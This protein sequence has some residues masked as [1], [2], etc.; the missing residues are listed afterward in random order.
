MQRLS[1]Y[2][3]ST[4]KQVIDFFE[5]II[6]G[7]S[8]SSR[9][10]YQVVVNSL[11]DYISSRSAYNQPFNI[12]VIEDW[13]IWISQHNLANKTISHYCDYLSGMYSAAVKNE[14]IEPN[15]GISRIRSKIKYID[16]ISQDSIIS[17]EK[18]TKFLSLIKKNGTSNSAI[19]LF[20]DILLM[21]LVN[22]C[23][24]ISSVVMLKR[25]DISRMSM[26]TQT[27]AMRHMESKR[28]FVFPLNQS[29]H[30][31]IQLQKIIYTKLAY[32]FYRYDIPLINNS[33]EE[34]IRSIWA[35][36]A[37]EC[38]AFPSDIVASLGCVPAGVPILS[39][40]TQRNSCSVTGF[41]S[42]IAKFFLDN[43]LQWFAMRLR[44]GVNINQVK[45]R[46]SVFRSEIGNVEIFY[47]CEEIAKKIGKKLIYNNRPIIND[48]AFFKSRT[49]DI[50]PMFC[51]ISDLAWCY[52]NNND[53][54]STY[55]VI[56]QESMRRFQ[57][58]IGQFTSDFEIAPIGTFE[59]KEGE[60]VVIIGGSYAGNEAEVERVLIQQTP[61]KIIYRVSFLGNNGIEW[62]VNVDSRMIKGENLSSL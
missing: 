10:N 15:D 59:I 11:K 30:T 45:K 42:K 1:E 13:V 43:P 50:Y 20:S 24:P 8:E 49:T 19:T 55:A 48:I 21:S 26:E 52:K 31:P 47:P 41:E 14:L 44:P 54:T 58:A 5:L 9:R 60:K 39:L 62:R 37:L 61:K 3:Q 53:S 56:S 7:Y 34:S 46:L 38:G 4:Q 6:A 12:H 27:I 35:F 40:C 29:R 22:K 36:V 33:I 18:I 28:K 23:M 2:K 16:S 51:H 17:T 25:V 32:E 57:I